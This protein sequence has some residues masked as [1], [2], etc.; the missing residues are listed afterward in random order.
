M[1]VVPG[2]VRPDAEDRDI[3]AFEPCEHIGF[4][5]IS[6]EEHPVPVGFD[7]ITIDP[8]IPVNDGPGSPVSRL[9]RFDMN[10]G[11]LGVVSARDGRRLAI[12]GGDERADTGGGNDLGSPGGQSPQG[13]AIEMVEVGVGDEHQVDASEALGRDWSR[14]QACGPEG[15]ASDPRADAFA[16]DRVYDHVDR[17]HAAQDRPMPDPRNSQVVG[18]ELGDRLG[19]CRAGGR[20]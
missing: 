20:A 17:S 4:R 1:H 6:C 10:P 3:D 7:D 19:G 13:G 2:F 8:P 5:G 15:S 12:A 14:D 18:P 9:D 16:E 11:D